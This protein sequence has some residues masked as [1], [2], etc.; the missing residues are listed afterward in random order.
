M[1][2]TTERMSENRGLSN[3]HEGVHPRP[4]PPN[5]AK[6]R[7]SAPLSLKPRGQGVRGHVFITD[8]VRITRVAVQSSPHFQPV[9]LSHRW[10][11]AVQTQ[12]LDELSVVVGDVPHRNDGDPEFGVRSSITAF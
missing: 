7:C 9:F 10:D 11:N 8:G 1:Q 5:G 3:A 12:I 6:R 2:S 4:P